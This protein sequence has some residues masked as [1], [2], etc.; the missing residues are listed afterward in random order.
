LCVCAGF[1]CGDVC[2]VAW[3]QSSCFHYARGD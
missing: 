3:R 2:A 1:L